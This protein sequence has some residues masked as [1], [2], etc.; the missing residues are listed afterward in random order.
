MYNKIFLKGRDGEA[1]KHRFYT[2]YARG[3]VTTEITADTD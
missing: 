3:R 1:L 2:V